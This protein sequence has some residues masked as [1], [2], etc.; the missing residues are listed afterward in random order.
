MAASAVKIFAS[1]QHSAFTANFRDI[2]TNNTLS[3]SSHKLLIEFNQ[4]MLFA[5][6]I[7]TQKIF[8]AWTLNFSNEAWNLITR[9]FLSQILL[10]Y[11]FVNIYHFWLLSI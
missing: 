9:Q 4:L 3:S 10:Q 6:N 11:I 1:L 5:H 7:S 8:Q 2:S